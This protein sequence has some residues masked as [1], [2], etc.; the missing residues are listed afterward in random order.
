MKWVELPCELCGKLRKF[1]YS[2]N[3]D[4]VYAYK[5][6][7][8]SCTL[9]ERNK[10]QNFS[11]RKYPIVDIFETID[12]QEKAYMFGFMWADGYLCNQQRKNIA[13]VKSLKICINSKDVDV[14][15][16]FI[17]HL[18]GSHNQRWIY[19][20]RTD[21]EYDQTT[22]MLHSKDVYD[23]FKR[24]GFREHTN[25]IPDELFNHFLRGLIDGDG[26][27]RYR[28]KYGIGIT[29]ASNYDQN[30]SFVTNRI[31]N[32][33]HINRYK[34]KTRQSK[35]SCLNIN[36][37]KAGFLRYIYKDS[38]FHLKRKYERIKNAI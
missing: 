13:S 5:Q 10:R 7:C 36:G 27:L 25:Y 38:I 33:Y 14:L 8:K 31:S 34:S 1:K 11:V 9:T 30:W 29:I 28:D 6:K 19:D 35:G 15:D 20:K 24:L 4:K 17:K 12:T 22:W 21:K 18:G 16:F 2:I 37:D 32:P 3:L 23:N 26:S